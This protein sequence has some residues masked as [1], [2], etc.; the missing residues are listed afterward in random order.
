MYPQARR[1]H[2]GRCCSCF[3]RHSVPR[4]SGGLYSRSPE[5][6]ALILVLFCLSVSSFPHLLS[7]IPNVSRGNSRSINRRK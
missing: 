3:V 4:T 6:Q 1:L 2:K 5:V 7:H